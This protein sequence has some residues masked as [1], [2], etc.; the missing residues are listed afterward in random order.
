MGAVD[1]CVISL[2]HCN[3][4]PCLSSQVPRFTPSITMAQPESSQQLE[5]KW[6]R[7]ESHYITCGLLEGVDYHAELSPL[8]GV[9]AF[10]LI[11]LCLTGLI[12]AELYYILLVFFIE[13]GDEGI[14]FAF[15]ACAVA[16]FNL[17]KGYYGLFGKWGTV[18]IRS[19]RS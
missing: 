12:I 8:G 2:R 13:F 18:H 5:R 16:S 15:G 9:C 1:Q 14:M 17:Y 7:V 6:A 11:Q 3:Q 10:R 19:S 4:A